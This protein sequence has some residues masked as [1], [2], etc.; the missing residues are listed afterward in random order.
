[1]WWGGCVNITR[2]G[3][4]GR[5]RARR[6]WTHPFLSSFSNARRRSSASFFFAKRSCAS[7]EV[8]GGETVDRDACFVRGARGE[9]RTPGA[10][11]SA[12][13]REAYPRGDGIRRHLRTRA[14]PG[15]GSEEECTRPSEDVMFS[16]RRSCGTANGSAPIFDALT[17]GREGCDEKSNAPRAQRV[18]RRPPAG[19]GRARP[20]RDRLPRP[21][22]PSASGR[23][24]SD[25]CARDR[26]AVLAREPGI[27]P[28]TLPLAPLRASVPTRGVRASRSPDHVPPPPR[29]L[30]QRRRAPRRDARL[31]PE[32]PPVGEAARRG[33]RDRER[34]GGPPPPR[35]RPRRRF[36]R[37]HAHA[38]QRRP[39]RLP[40]AVRSRRLL[41]R[42]PRPPPPRARRTS[43]IGGSRR[44][45]R[46]KRQTPTSASAPR[47]GARAPRRD[48]R[49][50]LGL[51]RRRQSLHRPVTLEPRERRRAR[52]SL[53]RRA[54]ATRGGTRRRSRGSRTRSGRSSKSS[55]SSRSWSARSKTR[56]SPRPTASSTPPPS[57]RRSSG[58]TGSSRSSSSG[59]GTPNSPPSRS[60]ARR[61]EVES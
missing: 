59:R 26:D 42:A 20:G 36:R 32:R 2:A 61:C 5:S 51:R 40:R 58:S 10:A 23:A 14:G 39:R 33:G 52:P 17:S 45:M 15:A 18:A 3:R 1:M 47:G 53:A 57:P 60:S 34:R 13:R 6:G 31:G 25:G 28:A 29:F 22:S 44:W 24:M 48:V 30:S 55:T 9:A 11:S 8:E 21:S 12:T 50:P 43:S 7:G 46:R 4:D 49:R 54:R 56:A 19:L 16:R 35:A 38:I 41:L 37:D 27:S